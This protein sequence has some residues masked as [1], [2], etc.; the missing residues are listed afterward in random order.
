MTL[1]LQKLTE[2]T[3]SFVDFLKTPPRIFRLHSRKLYHVD[4]FVTKISV[5][6][7][8]ITDPADWDV[9]CVYVTSTDSSSNSRWTVITSNMTTTLDC[10]SNQV[11]HVL[12]DAIVLKKAQVRFEVDIQFMSTLDEYNVQH[13]GAETKAGLKKAKIQFENSSFNSSLF[14]CTGDRLRYI[15][16]FSKERRISI[17]DPEEIKFNKT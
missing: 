6:I 8:S 2:W 1:S 5:K 11:A 12:C 16:D 9:N 7:T 10:D 3:N 17:S 4:F 13:W 14:E 15:Y